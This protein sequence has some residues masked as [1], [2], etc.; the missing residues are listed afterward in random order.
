[1]FVE[2]NIVRLVGKECNADS[3]HSCV[4]GF[5]LTEESSVRDEQLAVGMACDKS[6]QIIE[7][8]VL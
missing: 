5:L 1:M 3:W 8:N 6:V 2:L 7:W 4:D